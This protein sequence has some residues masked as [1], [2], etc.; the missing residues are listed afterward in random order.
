MN[1]RDFAIGLGAAP[2]MLGSSLAAV[3]PV[4]GKDYT[5]LSSP[6]PVA[7]AG[8]VEVIEF[9]GYWCP[10][11]NELE[12]KLES[13]I[14]KFPDDVN[15]RRIPVAWQESHVP[16]QRLFYA[17]ESLGI[18]SEI[19]PKV[20]QA[21]HGQHLRL[22]IEAGLVIFAAANGIDRV[23]LT[24]AMKGFAVA[25]KVRTANQLFSAFRLDGVPTLAISGRF[26]TSPDQAG[27]EDQALQVADALIRKSRMAR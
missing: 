14:R 5:R 3:D 20:F 11:C 25:N 26:L 8:K 6:I 12:P 23:K 24:D 15:F 21:V 22:D 19:H 13:W 4:E 18:G 10:H 2:L 7:V 27:G 16:F 17:L 9:F 1:R